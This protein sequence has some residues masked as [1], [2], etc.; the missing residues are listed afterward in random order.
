MLKTIL[1]NFQLLQDDS[2]T[3]RIFSQ[4]LLVS[5]KR[6]E[7]FGN[8]LIKSSPRTDEQ[9]GSFKCSH[10]RCN[11][12]RFIHNTVNISGPKCSIK[13]TNCFNCTST[14]VIYCITCTLCKMLY[15]GETGTRLGDHFCKHL[16]DVRNNNI[17]L[18]LNI[19]IFP[20]ILLKTWLFAAF[21]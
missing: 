5:C 17:C 4:P 19:S 20:V 12:C 21:L 9:P 3:G 6:D 10:A 7:N 8:F 11:T 2:K 14:D 18:S 1:T 13:V 16:R 15:I